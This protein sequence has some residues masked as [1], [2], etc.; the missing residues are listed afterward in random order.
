MAETREIKYPD[1]TVEL[2]G[3]D[4]NAFMILG[5]VQ[6]ALRKVGAT[7]EEIRAFHAEAT[8]GDYNKVLQTCMAWVNVE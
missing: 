2:S 8:S 5:L 1:V 7:D 6:K 3:Q 4:G